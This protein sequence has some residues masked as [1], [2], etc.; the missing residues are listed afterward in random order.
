MRSFLRALRF[1]LFGLAPLVLAGCSLSPSPNAASTPLP[2]TGMAIHGTVYGGEVPLVGSHIYLLEANTSGYG[3][4]GIAASSS[5]A[6]H[7]LLNSSVLTNPS[8]PGGEDSNSNYYVTSVGS[9]GS[10]SIS[11]EY[12]CTPGEQVYLYSVGGAPIGGSANSAAGLLAALGNCPGAGT[13][14][15]SLY[16]LINEVSTVAAAY[17]MA[18]FASDALHVST[19]G[20][21]LGQ[22][23]LLNAF[24]NA[25]NLETLSGSNAGTAPTTT[26]GG[27]GTVPQAEIY[28]LANIL[29]SCVSSSGPGSSTCNT[30][31]TDTGVS[32]T[33]SAAISIA[34]KPGANVAALYGLVGSTGPFQP[35]LTSAPNDFTIALNFSGGGISSPSAIAIDS[36]GDAWI[37][38]NASTP[39]VTELGPLGVPATGSPYGVALSPVSIAIDLSGNAW[40]AC[41]YNPGSVVALSSTGT[42]LTGSPF[43]GGGV[44][45]PDAVAVDGSNH[46]WVGNVG[47][48]QNGQLSE[49][50]S[51]GSAVTGSP[52]GPT[53]GAIEAAVAIDLSGNVWTINSY[54]EGPEK[55][56]FSGGSLSSST[57]YTPINNPTGLA[58][59]ASNHIW[60]STHGSN[61]V[62]LNTS[63]TA[64]AYTGGA[65]QYSQ[66]IAMDGASNA[67]IANTTFTPPDPGRLSEF[68]NGGTALTPS[69]GYQS[70][71]MLSPTG[72]AV[73]SA[74]DVWVTNKGNST[75]SEF[76][77]AAVPVTTPL[78]YGVQ[79]NLL[80]TRP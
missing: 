73:D 46:I 6:S 42:P 29:A 21:I 30:L 74:G 61:V 76:I 25:A 16:I 68:S 33:A 11:G 15:S 17:A 34:Q 79:F 18:G 64:V 7:S 48:F 69:T 77:G 78:A 24:A 71:T 70:S 55:F 51:S 56:V 72:I 8:D 19:S 35:A 62:V 49:L 13:F 58:V 22:L 20:S 53:F 47:Q 28:T 36:T 59:D 54:L 43:T 1:S 23:G 50:T 14:S 39:T 3:G 27:N 9:I 45:E 41:D 4:P 60:Y 57:N 63:G 26:P 66:A 75:V 31:L 40:I 12:S 5:N 65:L 2:Q 52:F 37:A 44:S 32:D 80:G 38:N 10:W 67:W